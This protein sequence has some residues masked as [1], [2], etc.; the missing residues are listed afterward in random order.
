MTTP[1]YPTLRSLPLRFTTRPLRNF[2]G[3]SCG[4]DLVNVFRVSC[5]T[6]FA[7]L[8]LDLGPE[9]LLES[10]VRFGFNRNIPLDVSPGAVRSFFP[11][12]DFFKRN[13]P[14]LAQSA[15]GQG[16]VSATT[17]QMAMVAAGVANKG[18]VME[19]HFMREVRS[20]DGELIQ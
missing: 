15:I 6:A 2:G 20:S 1:I 14:Q 8:G 12:V 10:A 18:V 4:G 5:N 11:P 7:Q 13:D 9:R 19:P 16:S 17:L 3:S